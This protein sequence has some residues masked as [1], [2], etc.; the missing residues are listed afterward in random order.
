M[1]IGKKSMNDSQI[2][3]SGDGVSGFGATEENPLYK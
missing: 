3:N 2:E 1:S